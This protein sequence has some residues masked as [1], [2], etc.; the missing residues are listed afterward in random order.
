M[1]DQQQRQARER[2]NIQHDA[3]R[4]AEARVSE[5]VNG[6]VP[7]FPDGS[8]LCL[9]MCRCACVRMCAFSYARVHVSLPLSLSLSL[10]L[11][12]CA[13][14]RVQLRFSPVERPI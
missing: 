3:A 4:R 2:E 8:C 11:C 9:F 5:R 6:W 1:A 12:V 13:R 14:V 7:S 10:S